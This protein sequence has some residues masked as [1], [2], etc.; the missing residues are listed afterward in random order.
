MYSI[1]ASS[2]QNPLLSTTYNTFGPT[3][4]TF[5]SQDSDSFTYDPNTGRETQYSFTV[6]GATETGTLTW[7]ANGTLKQ[8]AINDPFS[9]S[10]TQT[11]ANS[12][13][14]L[15]RLVNNNCGSVWNQSYSY[16]PL[17]KLLASG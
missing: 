7:N 9:A 12:Y 4:V 14:D 11:C 1:S 6:N 15:M 2:G 8:L 10:N 5:G 16:D 13:D 17:S 3:S